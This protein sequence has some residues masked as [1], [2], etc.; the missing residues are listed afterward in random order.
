MREA[1]QRHLQ[2]MQGVV[3]SIRSEWSS[4]LVMQEQEC[5][6]RLQDVE[7]KA[8]GAYGSRVYPWNGAGKGSSRSKGICWLR[9]VR[10]RELYS[11]LCGAEN[12]CAYLQAL[13]NHG[14]GIRA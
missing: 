5:E 12:T 13:K 10:V 2:I 1:E 4:R 8:I 3:D 14:M 11:E 6:Q 9:E 7:N